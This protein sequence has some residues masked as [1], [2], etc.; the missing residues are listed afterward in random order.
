MSNENQLYIKGIKKTK[1]KVLS[2]ETISENEKIQEKDEQ[3]GLQKDEIIPEKSKENIRNI[4][5]KKLKGK[6]TIDNIIQ[7]K[8]KL[9]QI[10]N[11]DNCIKFNIDRIYENKNISKDLEKENLEKIKK[12]DNL[13]ENNI[14]NKN[15][16]KQN[17]ILQPEGQNNNRFTVTST[18]K[19]KEEITNITNEQSQNKLEKDEKIKKDN[20]NKEGEEKEKNVKSE[21]EIKISTKKVYRKNF[22][23]KN[24]FK[25]NL[26]TSE[27][28]IN[29]SERG[30]IKPILEPESQ[31]NNRFTIN[32][33]IKD[34]I[35]NKDNEIDLE[36]INK[37]EI[38]VKKLKN[39]QKIENCIQFNIDRSYDNKNILLKE[40]NKDN[41]DIKIEKN[42][43]KSYNE[44][45]DLITDNE[46]EK[47]LNKKKQ[48][49][50][51]TDE[52]NLIKNQ[53]QKQFIQLEPE[54]QNN[55]RFEVLNE[56]KKKN[57]NQ[58][59]P[60]NEIQQKEISLNIISDKSKSKD[61]LKL[62]VSKNKELNI[63]QSER[64]IK[65]STKKVYRKNIKHIFK[66]NEIIS[67]N[68]LNISGIKK[69]KPILEKEPQDNNRFTVEK[70]N[71]DK[72]INMDNCIQFNIES[73]Q[74][75]FIQLEPEKQIN[76]RFIIEKIKDEKQGAKN[77]PEKINQIEIKNDYEKTT[78]LEI[79]KNEEINI[80]R[81][82]KK[83]ALMINKNN[84]INLK[85]EI[86]NKK[87]LKLFTNNSIIAEN[88]IN[89]NGKNKTNCIDKIG[90]Q[91]IISFTIEKI[92][93]ENELN[94][95]KLNGK[96][97]KPE[98][99]QISQ[100]FSYHIPKD[101]EKIKEKINELISK[102]KQ[103]NL[104][105]L[106]IS[107]NSDINLISNETK[108]E[109]KIMTKKVY[110][111]TNNIFTKFLD[112]KAVISSQNKFDI[113]GN[114]KV[115]PKLFID[116][117]NLIILGKEKQNKKVIDLS[118]I[119]ENNKITNENLININGNM[120]KFDNIQLQNEEEKNINRFSI[121]KDSKNILLYKL[122]QIEIQTNVSLEVNKTKK[123]QDSNSLKYEI[124][125]IDP[126]NI[127]G[128]NSDKNI[129]DDLS[130]EQIE[131]LKKKLKNTHHE[132]DIVINIKS[133]FTINGE[134][135]KKVDEKIINTKSQFTIKGET[136]KPTQNIINST[137]RFSVDK[138]NKKPE[139]NI[140]NTTNKFTINKIIKKP[141]ENVINTKSQ[142]TINS[143]N[144][145]ANENII[146]TKSQFTIN[147]L[148]KK[149]Q[150]KIIN[151]I[152][153][154]SI[155]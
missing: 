54:E 122:K 129:L 152:S 34:N 104:K 97:I 66:N 38:I 47:A 13:D 96:Q 57:I 35:K 118:K 110:K 123:A 73:I 56:S 149:I 75:Q 67:E 116:N 99:L 141:E 93:N 55:Y 94:K 60:E 46:K 70:E 36:N 139:V 84:E 61:K 143:I 44:K 135:R 115:Q 25:N 29:I 74:K 48:K 18:K 80:D 140:I 130:K 33:N 59:K 138:I 109:I 16:S 85:G 153:Q 90:P 8:K 150:E 119:N 120:K 28:Q 146:N 27:N 77:I 37:E 2:K 100:S 134:R 132:N 15:K 155:N 107:K 1:K 43:D 5:K 31:E 39:I 133:Q 128:G 20:K 53:N 79:I 40:D 50:E 9:Q 101:E 65:I 76:N 151:T 144:K 71:K 103:A 83:E 82:S 24:E 14:K 111:K 136:K 72:N 124:F 12:E 114:E 86:E 41:K 42:K 112:N 147:G 62:E 52:S 102:N 126:V 63:I 87:N 127:N 11:I 22:I 154:F 145:K 92:N 105:S 3:N 142:F 121:E 131:E 89:I 88:Q 32:K 64:E 106:E 95:E 148:F 23:H 49:G 7:N 21:R 68:K 69:E 4:Y 26:I 6:K 98:E 51:P 113:E 10:Q 19:A 17:I 58:K 78:L 125:K 91:D 108:R 137:S 117:N 81:N 45:L 30:N